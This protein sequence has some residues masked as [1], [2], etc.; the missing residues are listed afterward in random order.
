MLWESTVICPNSPQLKSPFEL[1]R[2]LYECWLKD[3]FLP[4]A[5]FR[6]RLQ[7]VLFTAVHLRA[8]YAD[9]YT[10]LAGVF[11]DEPEEM[12]FWLDRALNEGNLS[13][14]MAFFQS[15]VSDNDVSGQTVERLADMQ[16]RVRKTLTEAEGRLRSKPAPTSAE[17]CRWVLDFTDALD[18]ELIAEVLACLFPKG[19]V[20]SNRSQGAGSLPA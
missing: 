6:D 1:L 8:R 15:R 20:A 7:S 2:S 18:E 9:F 5:P 17:V 11:G 19:P 3:A 4:R 12:K 16:V 13:N 10:R 14:L